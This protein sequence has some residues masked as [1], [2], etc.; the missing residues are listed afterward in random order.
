MLVW[1]NF[2]PIPFQLLPAIAQKIGLILLL[3][4]SSS[5]LAIAKPLELFPSNC[6]GSFDINEFIS[7]QGELL[8]KI[9]LKGQPAN[10]PWLA[11][12][13]EEHCPPCSVLSAIAMEE[14]RKLPSYPDREVIFT[15]T[16]PP[17]A[18]ISIDFEL[19]Q[20]GGWKLN[21]LVWQ[22]GWMT[23]KIQFLNQRLIN[24]DYAKKLL[25]IQ[26][27]LLEASGQLGRQWPGLGI[28]PPVALPEAAIRWASGSK[29]A[30]AD[31]LVSV[32]HIYEIITHIAETWEGISNRDILAITTNLL[33]LTLHLLEGLSH[34]HQT[35]LGNY[36]YL[37]FYGDILKASGH[38]QLTHTGFTSTSLL[39]NFVELYREWGHNHGQGTDLLALLGR[40]HNEISTLHHAYELWEA[41][42]DWTGGE[43]S[44]H[45]CH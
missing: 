10:Y 5:K 15:C 11:P 38:P 20:Q 29:Y 26:T 1:T 30:A 33:A 4:I 27:R 7:P 6:T 28:G 41:I 31:S 13:D 19:I 16:K 37:N 9:R 32:W 34:L 36:I 39:L 3:H 40:Y 21:N 23:L 35:V 17:S 44:H 25:G 18:R 45:H 43:T 2:S 24:H 14:V 22:A 8:L 12:I 42:N